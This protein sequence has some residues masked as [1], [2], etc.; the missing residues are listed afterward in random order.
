[1]AQKR[2]KSES[3]GWAPPTLSSEHA[4]DLQRPESSDTLRGQGAEVFGFPL[5]RLVIFQENQ[6]L[7]V[8]RVWVQVTQSWLQWPVIS[9]SKEPHS[10]KGP[11]LCSPCLE[12][13]HIS[14]TRGPTLLCPR[15]SFLTG[16]YKLGSWSWAPSEMLMR[17]ERYPPSFFFLPYKIHKQILMVFT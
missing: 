8:L 9:M 16:S 11:H 1:M 6:G 3:L 10:Q 13:P 7:G 17:K 5:V 4:L 12:M 2:L 15:L 14:L